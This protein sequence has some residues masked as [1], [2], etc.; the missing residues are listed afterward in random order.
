MSFVITMPKKAVNSAMH[1]MQNTKFNGRAEMRQHAEV[2]ELLT[3]KCLAK[4]NREII[5]ADG[6]KKEIDLVDYVPTDSEIT[7][8]DKSFKFFKDAVSSAIDKGQ[9]GEYSIGYNS[10]WNAVE[11]AKETK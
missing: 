6:S 7:L 10:L 9:T 3:E 2:T 11:S 1:V 5:L 4:K 8:D